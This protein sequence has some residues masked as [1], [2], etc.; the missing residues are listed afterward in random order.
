MTIGCV[1]GASGVFST[2]VEIGNG[3][4][5]SSIGWKIELAVVAFNILVA[6]VSATALLS[7]PT[8]NSVMISSTSTPF[9]KLLALDDAVD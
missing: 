7:H 9:T 6:P 8:S 1:I 2:D 4:D 3:V 5:F